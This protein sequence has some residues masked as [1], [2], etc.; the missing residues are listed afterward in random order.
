MKVSLALKV[1]LLI[2]LKKALS[3]KELVV[4]IAGG[5]LVAELLAMETGHLYKGPVSM[6]LQFREQFLE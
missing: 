1:M 3:A 4:R 6:S 5:P 2:L